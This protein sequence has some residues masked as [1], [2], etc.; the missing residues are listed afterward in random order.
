LVAINAYIFKTLRISNHS[1]QSSRSRIA[2]VIGFYTE[3]CQ[4]R[5]GPSRLAEKE[6]EERLTTFPCHPRESGGEKFGGIASTKK[7]SDDTHK[8]QNPYPCFLC[9]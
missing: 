4:R 3:R 7:L 1:T 8:N 2:Q 9:F 5:I 6:E